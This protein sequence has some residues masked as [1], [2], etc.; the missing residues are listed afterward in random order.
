MKICSYSAGVDSVAIT[1]FMMNHYGIKNMFHYNHN[2]QEVNES[3][4]ASARLFSKDF[5]M[6]LIFGKCDKKLKSES[7]YRNA[8]LNSIIN[9]CDEFTLITGHHLNDAVESYLLNCF[10]GNPEYTP[11]PLETSF[12]VFKRKIHPFLLIPKVDMIKYVCKNNLEKYVVEDPS[13]KVSKG[14]RRNMIRNEI[15]PILERDQIGIETIVKKRYK[16]LIQ[17]SASENDLLIIKSLQRKSVKQKESFLY[18]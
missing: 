11:I 3:M 15:L 16:I 17:K 14:S 9:K 4:E 6:N 12:G 13:N 2:Y 18:E 8:R 7:E 10:R 1:H 5:N